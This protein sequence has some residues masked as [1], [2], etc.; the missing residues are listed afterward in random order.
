MNLAEMLTAGKETAV[1]KAADYTFAPLVCFDSIFQNFSREAVKKGA[2]IIFVATN[3]SWY[4][5][6][7][8]VYEHK[9]FSVLRAI[10]TGRPVVRAANTGISCIIDPRGNTLAQTEP[11]VQDIL[12]NQHS[13]CGIVLQK[14]LFLQ[15]Y[16]LVYL[17]WRRVAVFMYYFRCGILR[18]R[19]L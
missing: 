17:D 9:N 13:M 10:E 14:S 2:D 18:I 6:T 7:R 8:G 3:D 1:I 15:H 16:H 5:S 12:Y 11:M 19:Y 4:K